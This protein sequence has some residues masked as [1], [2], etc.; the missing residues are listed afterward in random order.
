MKVLDVLPAR[1][2]EEHER[3]VDAWARY[4]WEAWTPHHDTVRRW[5]RHS[6]A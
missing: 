3:L 4:V 2:P 5:V 1:M 6:L